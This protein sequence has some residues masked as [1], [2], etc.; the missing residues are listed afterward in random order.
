[1]NRYLDLTPRE[2]YI[3]TIILEVRHDS[4]WGVAIDKFR[5]NPTPEHLRQLIV[6]LSDQAK[7]SPAGMAVVIGDELVGIFTDTHLKPV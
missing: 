1:M 7:D 4:I 3:Y 2:R 6:E 5:E